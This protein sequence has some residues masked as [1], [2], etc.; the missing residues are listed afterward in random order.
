MEVPGLCTPRMVMQGEG[1]GYL[2]EH[3][4][5]LPLR[6]HGGVQ[7]IA[8]AVLFLL[9]SQFIAGQVIYVDGGRHLYGGGL[10]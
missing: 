1:A 2:I 3:S 5:R 8:D 6:K 9:Q 4:S 10:A 7:D